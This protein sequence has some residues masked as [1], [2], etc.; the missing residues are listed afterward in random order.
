[1]FEICSDQNFSNKIS[2][3]ILN[4]VIKLS[5]EIYVS[6]KVKVSEGSIPYLNYNKSLCVGL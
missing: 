5:F 1:M 6:K 3:K 2:V 4:S